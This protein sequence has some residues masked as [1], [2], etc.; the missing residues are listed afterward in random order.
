VGSVPKVLTSAPSF[1]PSPSVSA[2]ISLS[3]TV[4]RKE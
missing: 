2:A 4:C 1:G 3:F